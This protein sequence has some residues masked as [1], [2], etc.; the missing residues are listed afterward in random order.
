MAICVNR[1]SRHS[2]LRRSFG[3]GLS[4]AQFPHRSKLDQ[5]P[6]LP[7]PD[8]K[9]GLVGQSGFSTDI[10]ATMAIQNLSAAEK[11]DTR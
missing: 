3:K 9:W 5:E 4:F 6:T 11:N 1:Q 2:A 10:I 7:Y 8:A